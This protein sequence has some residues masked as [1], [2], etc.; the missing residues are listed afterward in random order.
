MSKQVWA[1][2][3]R[4]RQQLNM[5]PLIRLRHLLPAAAGRRGVNLL[6]GR[7]NV[8]IYSPSPPPPVGEKVPKAD[9]GALIARRRRS[10]AP[11]AGR[12]TPHYHSALRT[13]LTG[14]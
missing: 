1:V 2:G 13:R 4:S 11:H 14:P 9:E 6:F 5:R 7:T 8:R 12:G 3:H 10:A